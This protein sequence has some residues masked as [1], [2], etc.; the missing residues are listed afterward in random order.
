M[1]SALVSGPLSSCLGGVYKHQ[2]D[3]LYL[4]VVSHSLTVVFA[5]DD[6]FFVEVTSIL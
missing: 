4:V 5:A 1:I 6:D 3:V 2:C